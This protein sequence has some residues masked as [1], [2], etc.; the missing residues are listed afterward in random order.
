MDLQQAKL[1]LK[2]KVNHFKEK[3]YP[4]LAA[5]PAIR[6]RAAR[7]LNA[8]ALAASEGATLEEVQTAAVALDAIT[9]RR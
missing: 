4:G 2:D 5:D 9:E 6:D 8:A 3:V 7:T 1:E